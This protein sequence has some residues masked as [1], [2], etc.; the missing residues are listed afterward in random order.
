MQGQWSRRWFYS[1]RKAGFT[2][3]L[4][5]CTASEPERDQNYLTL[6]ACVYIYTHECIYINIIS[7]SPPLRG[8]PKVSCRGQTPSSMFHQMGCVPAFASHC[9]KSMQFPQ[10]CLS[11]GHLCSAG[12]LLDFLPPHLLSFLPFFSLLFFFAPLLFSLLQT[13]YENSRIR[14]EQCI[15]TAFQVVYK[16]I[17]EKKS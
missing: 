13:I 11:S 9:P 7:I 14:M 3:Q 12:C 10:T 15:K 4:F 8:I 1:K 6:Y 16:Q 2:V 17:K 5:R